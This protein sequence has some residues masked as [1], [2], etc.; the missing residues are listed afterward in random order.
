MSRTNGAQHWKRLLQGGWV[1]TKLY[2]VF[3]PL[4]EAKRKKK[5]G[6]REENGKAKAWIWQNLVI[7]N[8]Q[9]VDES[10]YSGWTGAV[11]G[12]G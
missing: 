9:W 4:K 11:Q 1:Q 5:N 12:R 8:G 10:E 6:V 3:A 7:F 2:N